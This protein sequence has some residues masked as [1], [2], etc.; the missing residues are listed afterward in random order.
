MAPEPAGTFPP[1]RTVGGLFGFAAH[2]NG[3]HDGRGGIRRQQ[4]RYP[5]D[6]PRLPVVVPVLGEDDVIRQKDGGVLDLIAV[7]LV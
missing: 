5:H 2:V 6:H 1:I 7:V 4:I 3:S